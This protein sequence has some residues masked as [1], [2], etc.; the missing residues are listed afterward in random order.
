MHFEIINLTTPQFNRN[1]HLLWFDVP[2]DKPYFEQRMQE[3]A[4]LFNEAELAIIKNLLIEMNAA[5][6]K[7]K[8]QG[9]SQKIR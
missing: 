7:A 9:L 6:E 2:N 4:S 1:H 5:T 8:E 3:G